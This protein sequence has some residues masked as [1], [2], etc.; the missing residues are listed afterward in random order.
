MKKL[1][2][3]LI[4]A[5][6]SAI[7][8]TASALSLT[9]CGGDA[10]KLKI[11][12][13]TLTGEQYGYCVN[14][15]DTTIMTEVNSLIEKLCGNS[16]Y[17]PENTSSFNAEGIQYDFDGNGTDETVTFKTIYDAVINGTANDIGE[18]PPSVP[19][20]KTPDDC[21]IVATNAEFEPFE[22]KNGN[23]YAG[24]DMWIAKILAETLNKTLVIKDME[25]DVV[26]TDV[27]TGASHI[28]MAGLTI[29]HGREQLVTFSKGYYKTTQ[30]IAVAEDETAFDSC[31]TEAQV[32]AVIEGMG[33]VNAG[34]ASG[35]TGYYYIVGSTD[36]EF[37]GFANVTAK[38]YDSIGLAVQNLSNGKLKFVVG[39]KDTLTS[40]VTEINSHIGK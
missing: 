3:K 36:F 19:A 28:G 20:G 10:S 4:V 6:V 16:A 22:Y 26:I 7:T 12:D 14:K 40:A 24:V 29:N 13:V 18:V 34:A 35:Q 17:D 32:R 37:A 39:D 1:A 2:K 30:S 33:K 21:L 38:D 8:I 27:E 15:T 23:K 25:F 9:A 5:A 11:L 31:T